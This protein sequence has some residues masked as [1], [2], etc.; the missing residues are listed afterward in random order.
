MSQIDRLLIRYVRMRSTT[1][2]YAV[3]NRIDHLLFSVACWF[4]WNYDQ[5]RTSLL[6]QHVNLTWTLNHATAVNVNRGIRSFDPG[7]ANVI[8]FYAPLTLI[9][10]HNGAGKT[11]VIECL[12]YATTGDLPPNC[13]S[14]AFIHDPRIAHETEVKAQIKLRFKNVNGKEMVCTRSMSLTQKKTSLTQ[15]TLES[16]LMTKN[17]DGEQVSISSKCAEL[18]IAMPEQLGVSKAILDNVIFCH[19]EESFWPLSEPATLKK[20]FDEI[21]ASTRYTKALV[22]IRD[23]RKEQTAQIKIDTAELEHLKSDKEKADQI[24]RDLA[25]MEERIQSVRSRRDELEGGEIAAVMDTLRG[26]E[27]Q[28]QIIQQMEQ[29]IQQHEMKRDI[30][31]NNLNELQQTIELFEDSDER[32]AI[33]LEE[34]QTSIKT[35]HAE[36]KDL[37]KDSEAYDAQL[38]SY[39][40]SMSTLLTRVGQLQAESDAYKR[41]FADFEQ[42]ID[43]LSLNW[44]LKRPSLPLSQDDVSYYVGKLKQELVANEGKLEKLKMERD[45]EESDVR[46]RLQDLKSSIMMQEESKRGTKR[47]MDANRSKVAD[48][49]RQIQSITVSQTDIDE[50][51]AQV[52]E[53]ETYVA[54]I[55]SSFDPAALEAK[56]KQHNLELQTKELTVMALHD[57]MA[58]LN[59]QADTRARLALKQTDKK[60]KLD[61]ISARSP[62]LFEE[63]ERM[64]RKKPESD[65]M[66]NELN[67]QNRAKEALLDSCQQKLDLTRK[68]LSSIEARSTLLKTNL[69]KKLQ[70]LDT[71]RKKLLVVSNGSNFMTAFEENE[72]EYEEELSNEKTFASAG[73]MFSKY[74]RSFESTQCCPLCTRGFETRAEGEA[75]LEKLKATIAKIPSKAEQEAMLKERVAK[76]KVF[77]DLKPVW[78]DVCRLENSEI[79]ELKKNISEAEAQREDASTAVEDIASE[80][81]A[82]KAEITSMTQLR[83]K[84][85]EIAKMSK[86]VDTISDEISQLEL[87][88]LASGSKKTLAEVQAEQDSVQASCQVLRRD[89]ERINT[90]LRTKQ[91]DL[92]RHENLVQERKNTLQQLEFKFQER[93]KLQAIIAEL[94][95]EYDRHTK[96][97]EFADDKIAEMQPRLHELEGELAVVRERRQE[98]EAKIL[99][100]VQQLRHD[101]SQVQRLQKEVERYVSSG[102]EKTLANS[103]KELADIRS[104]M[105]NVQDA[106]AEIQEKIGQIRKSESEVIVVQ[107][108]ISDNMKYREMQRN[109][110]EINSQIDRMLNKYQRVDTTSVKS[111]RQMHMIR[112]EKLSEELATLAGELKQL[113]E[114]AKRYSRDLEKD[115]S[116]VEQL[117]KKQMIKLKTETLANQDLEKYSKALESAIMKYHTMKMDEI[118]KIIRE[119][120]VNTYK[121]NDIET[122]EI[123]SD[124]VG[125]TGNRSYNYRVVM[126][127][128]QTEIDMRGRCSAGQK[129]LTSLIIRLALAETFGLN[130]GILALDEPTTNLDRENSESLAESLVNII[131]LR[132]VQKNFQLIIITHDEDFMRLLGQSEFADYYWRISKDHEGHSGK[133]L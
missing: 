124:N 81:A 54:S 47:Q 91:R 117:H 84:C 13:K 62:K 64:F 29:E 80:L 16:L 49:M 113:E 25:E 32:L 57:E 8:E 67:A 58:A 99:K 82:L 65:N 83:S 9:V 86:E 44:K 50:A 106:K 53:E 36:L 119:L 79:P 21:F 96:D 19:Q 31:Q 125:A 45:A 116:N 100:I 6:A 55:K 127:K 15:K 42:L 130:C 97:C 70:E 90:E 126:I 5:T 26:L 10:G 41:T 88:L 37:E 133:H 39:E 105:K 109:L 93:D 120:W 60:R 102:G 43:T 59:M 101:T 128:E 87:E 75:F 74:V 129:V 107:R 35:K 28:Q 30:I 24:R 103:S 114:Q 112:Y 72:R 20:K 123:R 78:N 40:R 7:T 98:D 131:K 52:T 76:R 104:K 121:G 68:N 108:T 61:M 33:M 71:K 66:V 3:I 48:V 92:Q 118:N 27:K 22:N 115:Y 46:M 95:S 85:E 77:E 56:L 111:Q 110:N 17:E 94:K 18:D 34:Y 69:T 2:V 51:T 73:A 132:R 4:G 23:V 11:T 89:I 12:K 14:G 122:I 38:T 1:V 63:Y